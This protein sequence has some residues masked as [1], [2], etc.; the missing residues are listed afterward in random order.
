MFLRYLTVYLYR[1]FLQG[2]GYTLWLL[3]ILPSA[4]ISTMNQNNPMTDL[5]GSMLEAG[6]AHHGLSRHRHR[7]WTAETAASF[8][9]YLQQL[10]KFSFS[11]MPLLIVRFVRLDFRLHRYMILQRRHPP[12]HLYRFLLCLERFRHLLRLHKS[13]C[14]LYVDQRVP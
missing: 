11:L 9:D 8:A 6:T 7:I 5:L 12:L 3:Q 14:S 4:L 2:N 10:I 13:N 1:L